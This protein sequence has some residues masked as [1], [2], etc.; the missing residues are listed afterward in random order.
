[1][2]FTSVSGKPGRGGQ[3]GG[4]QL[5]IPVG[6]TTAAGAIGFLETTA[7]QR[8]WG[9]RHKARLIV[10]NGIAGPVKC[11]PCQCRSDGIALEGATDHHSAQPGETVAPR[12]P[13][14]NPRAPS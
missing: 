9:I 2:V 7:S 4:P 14:G 6:L 3:E 13:P 12:H 8:L 11:R 10:D 5:L 1:M